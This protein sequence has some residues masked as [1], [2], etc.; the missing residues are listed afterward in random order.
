MAAEAQQRLTH[1][2]DLFNP[3]QARAATLCLAQLTT[4]YLD[5]GE[6]DQAVACGA[7]LLEAAAGIRSGRLAEHLTM[8][9]KAAAAHINMA[10]VKQLAAALDHSQQRIGP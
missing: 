9:R 2:L 4:I 5:A 3:A 6:H 7:R 10:A 8:V 1:A